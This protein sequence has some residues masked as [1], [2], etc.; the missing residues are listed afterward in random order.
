MKADYGTH[1]LQTAEYPSKPTGMLVED[2][3]LKYKDFEQS[4][5]LQM[6][7]LRPMRTAP[8]LRQMPTMS[9]EEAFILVPLLET[10]VS[11][12]DV[13]QFVSALRL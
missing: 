1:Q 11:L 12:I 7:L 8:S 6:C 10:Q 9:I 13:D 4:P 3:C 5:L 2:T